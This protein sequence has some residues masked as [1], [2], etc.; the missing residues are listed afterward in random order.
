MITKKTNSERL[1]LINMVVCRLEKKIQAN[2]IALLPLPLK[3]KFSPQ[4]KIKSRG[5]I[6]FYTIL[7]W[8]S[9]FCPLFWKAFPGKVPMQF[10]RNFGRSFCTWGLKSRSLTV[11]QNQ[12]RYS[13]SFCTWALN[14]GLSEYL[15]SAQYVTLQNIFHV[16]V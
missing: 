14:Q 2:W 12:S 7:S 4:N 11:L 15:S 1:V 9:C 5:F 10:P 3:I 13:C 6:N 16:Q 8:G